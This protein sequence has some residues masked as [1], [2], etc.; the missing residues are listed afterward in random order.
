MPNIKRTPLT[1]EQELIAERLKS[2]WLREKTRLELTQTLA[3]EAL[4]ITQGSFTQY[5]STSTSR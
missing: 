5:L 3:A 1:E 4:D 2:A